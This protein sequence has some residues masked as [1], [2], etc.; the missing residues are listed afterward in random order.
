MLDIIGRLFIDISLIGG[1]ILFVLSFSKKFR[2]HRSKMLIASV[3]FII[4]G[5]IFF[6]SAALSEAYQRGRETGG[7]MK[8]D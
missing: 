1:I 2:K 8:H 5:L 7:I 4:V 6:D 3:L